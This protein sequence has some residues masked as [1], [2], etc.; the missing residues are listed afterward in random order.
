MKE[1]LHTPEGVRDIYGSEYDRKKELQRRIEAVFYDFGYEGIETPSFEFFDIFNK[2][3][4]SVASRE[5]FKF[6]DREGNTMVLRPDMTP[7]IARS[8]SKYYREEVLPVRLSYCG[9]IFINNSSYQGRLKESTQAG[10][11]CIGDPSV[12]AEAEMIAMVVVALK[13]VGLQEFQIDLGQVE[14]FNGLV[15]E[16]GLDEETE[17]E[18]RSRI[19]AKNTFGVEELILDAALPKPLTEAFLQLPQLFGSIECLETARK[20]TENTR[21]LAAID[22]LK[23][24]YH[25]LK[26]YGVESYVSFDLGMLGKYQYYSGII[27]R[28]FTYGTGEPLGGG[29]R[30]DHLMKQFGKDTAAVGF[31]LSIDN[32]MLAMAR[33]EIP[34]E[35]PKLDTIVVYREEAF[36]EAIRLSAELRMARKACQLHLFTKPEEEYVKLMERLEANRILF[37]EPEGPRE[38]YRKVVIG[39]D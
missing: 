36:E 35:T 21:A 7:A 14:F 39:E 33:Q 13:R 6:F 28:I 3:R 16:A 10:A 11:E 15:E 34:I 19:E 18:L 9:N 4:G 17:E 23:K 8:A 1:L 26:V 20:L 30:Y 37:L 32:L 22:R 38:L 29:G 25:L 31:G 12:D 24:L 5:M 2:E 27:F